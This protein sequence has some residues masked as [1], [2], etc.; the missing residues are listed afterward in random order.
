MELS[1]KIPARTK[2]VKFRW[3]QKRFMQCSEKYRAIRNKM[4][5]PMQKC[6]W[7]GYKFKTGEWIGLAC[8]LPGQEGPKR[9]WAICDD[10]G[11][12]MGAPMSKYFKEFEQEVEK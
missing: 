6:D 2:T 5:S 9:N 8:P 3:A 11:D 4:R 12:L 10:C 1:K 7:C